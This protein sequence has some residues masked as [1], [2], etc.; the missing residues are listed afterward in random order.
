MQKEIFGTWLNADDQWDDKSLQDD[1]DQMFMDVDIELDMLPGITAN[2][3]RLERFSSWYTDG[4]GSESK[5]ERELERILKT[6]STT[7]PNH[8]KA[9]NIQ[10]R[11]AN[12]VFCSPKPPNS[13]T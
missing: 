1:Q 8:N 7:F 10:W 9:I 13:G 11:Y 3:M 4:S 2:M 5:Y 6:R 12:M